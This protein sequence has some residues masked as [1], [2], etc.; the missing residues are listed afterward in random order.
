MHLSTEKSYD[1][2]IFMKIVG[3]IAEFNPFH[4]GHKHLISQ[5]RVKTGCDFVVVAMSGDFVQRGAPAIF[6]KRIRTKAALAE[7]ADMV[8]QLPVI[9]STA[10]AELFALCGVKTLAEAGVTTIACGCE[11]NDS[12]TIMKIAKL[13]VEEP[14]EYQALLHD[15]L[16]RGFSFPLARSKALST[17][18][19]DS[20]IESILSS[21]NNILAIEYYKAIHRLNLSISLTLI[22]RIGVG[23]HDMCPNQEFASATSIRFAIRNG[24]FPSTKA[25]LPTSGYRLYETYL[26]NYRPLYDDCFSKQLQYQMIILKSDGFTEYLDV[27]DGLNNRI[28]GSLDAYESHSQFAKLIQTKDNTYTRVSRVF[29]HILLQITKEQAALLSSPS[30]RFVPY[31]RVLGFHKSSNDLLRSIQSHSSKPLILS[32]SQGTN[33]LSS[34]EMVFFRLDE[35]ARNLYISQAGMSLLNDYQ[36][37]LCVEK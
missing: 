8:L 17:Y 16:K 21:P 6:D 10:S 33:H 11:T 15:N 26:S 37:P 9:A 5:A 28:I 30:I 2:I 25:L 7:G 18:C 29:T 24:E 13:L 32:V 35:K 27:N 22:P 12:K 14:S 3:I 19:R 1:I 20:S 36:L 23:H 34:E 31:L 4:N